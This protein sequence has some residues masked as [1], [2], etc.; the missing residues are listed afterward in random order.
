MENARKCCGESAYALYAVCR[1]RCLGTD[2]VEDD[3]VRVL[4]VG[5]RSGTFVCFDIMD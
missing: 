2:T 3:C 1:L 5:Q 4:G